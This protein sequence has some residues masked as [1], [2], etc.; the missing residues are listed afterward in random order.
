MKTLS[1]KNPWA[2]MIAAGVKTVENRG[3]NTNYRGRIF[4]HASG[5]NLN[6]INSGDMPPDLKRRIKKAVADDVS[7]NQLDSECR[8]FN[9]I[10]CRCVDHYH[11]SDMTNYPNPAQA[12][13]EAQKKYGSPFPSSAIIGEVDIVD[14]IRDSKS[15]WAAPYQAHWLL[16]NP[17]LY[18]REKFILNIKGKLGLWN[19]DIS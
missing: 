13:I 12:I 19:Y 6:W 10:L 17:V 1:I 16:E 5:S 7:E 11:L 2:T 18:E 8:G 3:Q 9:R 15:Y 14:C 4:I